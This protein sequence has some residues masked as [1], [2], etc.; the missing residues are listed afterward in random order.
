MQSVQSGTNSLFQLGGLELGVICHCWDT[1]AASFDFQL[2]DFDHLLKVEQFL[3]PQMSFS[4][5]RVIV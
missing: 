5:R 4:W 2:C 1:E 3:S